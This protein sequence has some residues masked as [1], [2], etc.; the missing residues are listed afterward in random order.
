MSSTGVTYVFAVRRKLRDLG[1]AGFYEFLQFSSLS[2]WWF[3]IVYHWI[4]D[5]IV[6]LPHSFVLISLV[7]LLRYQTSAW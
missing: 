1:G 4:N 2:D 6:V 5:S 7:M 3:L